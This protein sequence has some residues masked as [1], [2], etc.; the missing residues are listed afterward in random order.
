MFEFLFKYP[1]AMYRKGSLVL[2]SGWSVWVLAAVLVVLLGA[3]LWIFWRK[4]EQWQGAGRA[5]TLGALQWGVLALLVVM[6]W[7]PALSVAS[8]RQQQNVVAVLID[9]SRSMAQVEDGRSRI[10]QARSLLDGS[11]MNQLKS[12]YAVR[13]YSVGGELRRIESAKDLVADSGVTHLG[14]AL[15]QAVGEAATLPVG[16]VVLLSD[17]ADNSGGL[18]QETTAAL[19]AARI[20]V[21]AVGLGR[22]TPENDIEISAVQ[23]PAR[24]LAGSKLNA[25]VTLR[26]FGH[27]GQAARLTVREGDKVL[28]S[29]EIRLPEDGKQAIEPLAFQA[30]DAAARVYRVGI[31]PLDGE[32]SRDNNVLTQLVNVEDRKPRILYMEGEPRWEMKFI[33]RAVEEDKNLELVSILRTTQNKIYRQG[34]KSASEL[35]NGFPD[36]VEDLFS[37]DALVIGAVEAGYF[38]GP[39]QALI[40]E[41][42]DR[43]GGGVLFLGGRNALSEGGWQKTQVAEMLP[44]ELPDRKNTFFRDPAGVQL[45]ARGQD[46]LVTR[47]EEDPVKNAARW[48]AFPKLADYQETGTPKP[49]ATV[50]AEFVSPAGRTYPLLAMQNYGRGRVA[51]LATGGTW[52]WQML[53]DSKD[54]THEVFWQQLMRWLVTGSSGRVAVSSTE[55]VLRDSADITLRA[56]VRDTNFLPLPEAAVEA[57]VIGPEGLADVVT[58]Q[59]DPQSPGQYS[60]KWKA[61][62]PGSYLAEVVARRGE[63][64]VAR[65]VLT[66]RREDGVAENFRTEQNRLLLER[67]AEQTGGR[68][69]TPDDVDGLAKEIDFSEAGISVRETHDLWD[70]PL[71][72]LLL[73]GLKGAEW[74]LRRRWG[75]V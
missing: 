14:T 12:K 49:G 21:H 41:F 75:A 9:S 18:D 60:A 52:K 42:A 26:Q 40:R 63:Q 3:L 13:L 35:E 72:F 17:G 69:Y 19:R 1:S 20:P 68:Y 51:L 6:L 70:M 7:Q 39:Q 11:L 71:A 22:A 53:Q 56:D 15:K 28:A 58:L 33:R 59:P 48:R 55:S 8:L 64:E 5:F 44:V 25:F 29:R 67:L 37:Y 32:R 46:S 23:M 45:T 62:K 27:S 4:R 54:Q 30:G 34:V 24:A 65:D 31:E 61:D 73:A 57:R 36:T 47:V 43:R 2:L 10:D 74:L 38:S 66:F 50:L 16:A